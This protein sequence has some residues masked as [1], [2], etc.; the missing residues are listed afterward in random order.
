MAAPIR[1]TDAAHTSTQAQ[2]PRE[3][4]TAAAR[5]AAK[6]KLCLLHFCN[7]SGCSLD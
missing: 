7:V 2:K 5:V 3:S 1:P 4:V 6:Q